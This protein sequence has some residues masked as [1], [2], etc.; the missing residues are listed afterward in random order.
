MIKPIKKIEKLTILVS[1]NIKLNVVK[2]ARVNEPNDPAIVLLGLIFVN[3]GPLKILPNTYPPISDA[4]QPANKT[5]KMNLD[6]WKLYNI[7]K[8]KQK[9]ETKIIKQIFESRL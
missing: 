6:C 7:K 9:I 4:T 2:L 3:F 5:N 1:R 8:D